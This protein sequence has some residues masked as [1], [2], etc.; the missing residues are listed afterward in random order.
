MSSNTDLPEW[1]QWTVQPETEAV[2]PRSFLEVN[3]I[4]VPAKKFD[5]SYNECVGG[6]IGGISQAFAW[7]ALAETLTC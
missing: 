6:F 3:H 1:E 5:N 4:F 7:S 2:E